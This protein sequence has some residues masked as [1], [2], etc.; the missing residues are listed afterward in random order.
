MELIMWSIFAIL[1]A[2][3]LIIPAIDYLKGVRAGPYIALISTAASMILLA[4]LMR[5]SGVMFSGLIRID[6]LSTYIAFIAAFGSFLVVL[7]SLSQAKDWSTAPS[8]YSLILLSLLG[9]LFIL[10]ANDASVVIASWA[11]V[12]VASYVIVGMRKDDASLEASV[13]YSLMGVASSSLLIFGFALVLGVTRESQLIQLSYVST[14]LREILVLGVLI[15]I[16]AVGFKMGVFPFHAWLPDV[17]GGANPLLVSFVSGVVKLISIGAFIRV[18][19][20]LIPAISDYWFTAMA[21]LSILTMFY[22]NLAALVQRNVQ[23]MM[24][25]SSIAQAGYFLIAFAALGSTKL[26]LQAIGLQVT[27]YVLA[28]IG[29]FVGLGYLSRKGFELTL[30]GLKGSGRT[31]RLSGSMITI[32]ILSLMGMPPLIGFWSKF[33]YIFFSVMDIAPWLALLGV[34][35]SG[36]SVGYYALVLRYMYFANPP[37]LRAREGSKDA[38]LYVLAIVGILSVVLGLGLVDHL[39]L[40]LS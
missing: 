21:I 38:E 11:L 14:Q 28:K 15:L 6:P 13:K 32:L 12:A 25:Y 35:N 9:V 36:I 40:L 39:V 29:I 26:A 37:E 17:Y 27:T 34:I 33:M 31:M 19:Q 16:A 3:G 24:A 30:D 5:K 1:S 2:A 18:L 8:L 20:P 10:Y 4:L 22:G 7:A 23:R